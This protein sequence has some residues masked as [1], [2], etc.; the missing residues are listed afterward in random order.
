M[1]DDLRVSIDAGGGGWSFAD[2]WQSGI[3]LV[4]GS[5][6]RLARR[7]VRRQRRH[8]RKRSGA[9][10]TDELPPQF[11]TAI[12]TSPKPTPRRHRQLGKADLHKICLY[13]V[14]GLLL[15]KPSRLAIWTPTMN[16]IASQ[17]D[18]EHGWPSMP[19]VGRG[20]RLESR[21]TWAWAPWVTLLF[22]LFAVALGWSDLLPAN[23]RPA[24]AIGMFLAVVRLAIVAIVVLMI[25]EVTL[26]L[27][28]TGL[29][30]VVVLVDDSA[31]MGIADRYDDAKLPRRPRQIASSPPASKS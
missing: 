25:A 29:P 12:A 2:T 23:V 14:L 17:L 7:A 19:P 27:R 3:Y 16:G 4:A 10:R 5:A 13:L 11:T 8:R 26:S 1:Q 22:A 9:R 6:R 21:L 31:S 15:S 28:R 30:T 20:N 24:A 18:L